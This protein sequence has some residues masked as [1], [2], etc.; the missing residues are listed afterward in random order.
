MTE[1]KQE[2]TKKQNQ[3]TYA[4]ID[5]Y[6]Y[7]LSAGSA[8]S[9]VSELRTDQN[10][11]Q[12]A[13]LKR[14]QLENENNN[15]V[16]NAE[17]QKALDG[18][19]LETFPDTEK[20]M[21][22][23][24]LDPNFTYQD[25]SKIIATKREILL[26][27]QLHLIEE[28]AIREKR[29]TTRFL[30]RTIDSKIS[31]VPY[32]VQEFA[33]PG[34]SSQLKNLRDSEA[35]SQCKPKTLIPLLQI[36]SQ[37]TFSVATTHSLGL[38]VGD[39]DPSQKIDRL[40][41]KIDDTGRI[42]DLL[43]ID[44]N[45]PESIDAQA[46]DIRF[47]AQYVPLII[48]GTLIPGEKPAPDF[49]LNKTSEAW[50]NTPDSL[51]QI[52]I[53]LSENQLTAEQAHLLFSEL[54]KVLNLIK[55]TK[56]SNIEDI[57][58]KYK[59]KDTTSAQLLLYAITD[60]M[61]RQALPKKLKKQWDVSFKE[62]EKKLNTDKYQKIATP[63]GSY[64]RG[65]FKLAL[66]LFNETNLENSTQDIKTLV[67]IYK[68]V[69][70][71]AD[72]IAGLFGDEIS[73]YKREVYNQTKGIIPAIAQLNP[74]EL[75]KQLRSLKN[76]VE[77]Q[78]LNWGEI[79]LKQQF[80]GLIVTIL[81]LNKLENKRDEYQKTKDHETDL[82]ILKNKLL[83]IYALSI[84][85][86]DSGM[87][88]PLFDVVDITEAFVAEELK[89]L[90]KITDE[91]IEEVLGETLK[92]IGNRDKSAYDKNAEARIEELRQQNSELQTKL[93]DMESRLG[94]DTESLSKIREMNSQ[95]N[96]EISHLR[97]EKTELEA[98]ISRLE[99]RNKRLNQINRKGR[100]DQDKNSSELAATQAE[101]TMARIQINQKD[102]RIRLLTETSNALQAKYEETQSII[103]QQKQRI[104][105]LEIIITSLQET[106]TNLKKAQETS[107]QQK[108]Q[109]S[110]LQTKL[111]KIR[112]EQFD[113]DDQEA[114]HLR[115]QLST[116]ESRLKNSLLLQAVILKQK[117]A[118]HDQ[119]EALEADNKQLK[120]AHELQTRE[121]QKLKEK[122][123]NLTSAFKA[124]HANLEKLEKEFRRALDVITVLEKDLKGELRSTKPYTTESQ[125]TQPAEISI[126]AANDFFG[127]RIPA[128]IDDLNDK[129]TTIGRKFRL[130]GFTKIY[131]R[132][133][134]ANL[135]QDFSDIYAEHMSESGSR[136]IKEL[137]HNL[138]KYLLIDPEEFRLI[139]ALALTQD[140]QQKQKLAYYYKNLIFYRKSAQENR[141]GLAE[142]Y[143]QKA[144]AEIKKIHILEDQIFDEELTSIFLEKV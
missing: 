127:T 97:S 131:E 55:S 112:L 25:L 62:Q 128:L 47:L 134:L 59:H 89:A 1:P 142:Q 53:A 113:G 118:L 88:I 132:C 69:M 2:G 26:L 124:Q 82:D 4:G 80:E 77:Q 94:D 109:I 10:S 36:L 120:E 9:Q 122:Y 31:G 91:K 126:E 78:G 70:R 17:L 18:I 79:R 20:I 129:S 86:E 106:I 42:E 102:E 114:E 30:P 72:Q 38:A 92:D 64:I 143:R 133:N 63:R 74:L 39:M 123:E 95:L 46:Q 84:T 110:A 8:I 56:Y 27:E 41:A 43:I 13:V 90:L 28:K 75:Q 40:R 139:M 107:S 66:R 117:V 101:L 21:S 103:E 67:A 93:A 61:T 52:Y 22:I 98:Q 23:A 7:P 87:G 137:V 45:A 76:F 29:I 105:E 14:P 65:D 71:L 37:L 5:Y 68:A 96:D 140:D 58:W 15:S 60:L 50:R 100:R 16:P 49:D 57:Y 144:E 121:L 24:K 116:A 85:I 19:S 130:I 12:E 51:H 141:R 111:E 104:S 136:I 73:E 33:P 81:S 35:I 83:E 11:P 54:I 6:V 119:L 115:S 135:A 32:L 3:Q 99:Q 44:W 48:A 125:L 108:N 34:I 138:Y